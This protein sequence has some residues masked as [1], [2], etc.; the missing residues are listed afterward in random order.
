MA[1][2]FAQY[3]Y[4]S[5]EELPIIARF[6]CSSFIQTESTQP[7]YM[8]LSTS[9][10]MLKKYDASDKNVITISKKDVTNSKLHK[11]VLKLSNSYTRRRRFG[12]CNLISFLGMQQF[13]DQM[14]SMNLQPY[15]FPY[16]THLCTECI[17]K[18]QDNI[19][20]DIFLTEYTDSCVSEVAKMQGFDQLKM[21][22]SIKDLYNDHSSETMMQCFVDGMSDWVNYL[23]TS[24][25]ENCKKGF[26]VVKLFEYAF[27]TKG[28]NQGNDECVCYHSVTPERFAEFCE[29]SI[30]Y[31]QSFLSATSN[32]SNLPNQKAYLEISFTDDIYEQIKILREY[33]ELGFLVQGLTENC[34]FPVDLSK[35]TEGHKEE[36]EIV[37]PPYYP[38]KITSVETENGISVAKA[39]SPMIVVFDDIIYEYM[40]NYIVQ[41]SNSKLLQTIKSR[42][43]EIKSVT[44]LK[45]KPGEKRNSESIIIVTQIPNK[46]PKIE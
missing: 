1:N 43:E 31:T 11:E 13:I 25:I 34:S 19:F 37:F 9:K 18:K 3:Y 7:Q 36:G 33:N 45:Q 30:V 12:G 17:G 8:L 44:T 14:K 5:I 29:G 26:A 4:S 42:I 16:M 40:E 38:I 10:E 35:L 21:A 46:Q 6:T 39:I 23:L 41:S 24:S 2:L 20:Y 27:A 28:N 22:Q 15:N 32:I